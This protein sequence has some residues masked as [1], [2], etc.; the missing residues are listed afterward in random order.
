MELTLYQRLYKKSL[1]HTEQL[2]AL[3]K[4][5]L[6]HGVYSGGEED[7]IEALDYIAALEVRLAESESIIE[8]LLGIGRKDHSNEKYDEIYAHA[9]AFLAG[10]E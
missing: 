9:A 2:S 6:Y 10:G 7:A 8:S 5:I 4:C 1:D 3:E